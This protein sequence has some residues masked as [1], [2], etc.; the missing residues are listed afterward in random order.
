MFELIKVCLANVVFNLSKVM[1]CVFQILQFS[2]LCRRFIFPSKRCFHVCTKGICQ[3]LNKY[4]EKYS[5][6][7]AKSTETT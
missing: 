5:E 6:N 7:G 2:L 4:W 1:Y 3:K